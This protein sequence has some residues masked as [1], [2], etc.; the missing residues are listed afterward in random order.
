MDSD[1]VKLILS[2]NQDKKIKNFTE[3]K[4]EINIILENI[5]QKYLCYTK[6]VENLKEIKDKLEEYQYVTFDDLN[7]GDFIRYIN[8]KYFYD[9]K[10]AKGGFISKIYEEEG[11]IQI[12]DNNKIYNLKFEN[13]IFF[14]KLTKEDIIKLTIIDALF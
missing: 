9:I 4:N 6:N 5:F 11:K 8:P 14:K 2:E 3:I 1:L 7:T 13:F 10:L 12:K